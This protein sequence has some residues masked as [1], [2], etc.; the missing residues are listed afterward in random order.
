MV[1]RSMMLFF[2]VPLWCSLEVGTYRIDCVGGGGC[3]WRVL[4]LGFSL[5]RKGLVRDLQYVG[6]SAEWQRWIPVGSANARFTLSSMLPSPF[7]KS[8]WYAASM[9]DLVPIFAPLCGA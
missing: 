5:T 1:R 7:L 6:K 8:V 4:P 3:S 2:A 9:G